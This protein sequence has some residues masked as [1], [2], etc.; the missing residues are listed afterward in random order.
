MASPAHLS[1]PDVGNFLHNL[2]P[3]PPVQFTLVLNLSHLCEINGGAKGYGELSRMNPFRIAG[4]YRSL[5][6]SGNSG[7]IRILSD[8]TDTAMG[9]AQRT[10]DTACAFGKDE[11]YV[12]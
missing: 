3:H 9:L 12:S 1:V 4:Q 10:I 5:D 7:N 8:E 2:L 6:I 11:D